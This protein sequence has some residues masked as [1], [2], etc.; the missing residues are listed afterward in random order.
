MV[1]RL[2]SIILSACLV[3]DLYLASL[4]IIHNNIP[5]SGVPS[6]LW[7][8]ATMVAISAPYD[9][10]LIKILIGSHLKYPPVKVKVNDWGVNTSVWE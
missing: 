4:A 3:W 2:G 1:L 5:C 6:T 7:G 9:A 8:L 10:S